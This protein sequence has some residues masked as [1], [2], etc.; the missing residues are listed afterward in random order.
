M[1]QRRGSIL[2]SSMGMIGL[3]MAAIMGAM[4]YVGNRNAGADNDKFRLLAEQAAKTGMEFVLGWAEASIDK[5]TRLPRSWDNMND[6]QVLDPVAQH[7]AAGVTTFERVRGVTTAGVGGILGPNS[8][9]EYVL[10]SVRDSNGNAAYV[11]S[12]KARVQ[13]F[14]VSEDMPRQFKVGVVG[15]VRKAGQNDPAV[16]GNEQGTIVA[17][18]VVLS[19]VGKEPV[20]RYAA[21]IDTDQVRNWVP[22]EV[23]DGPVHINRGYVDLQAP[24]QGSGY[25]NQNVAIGNGTFI[26]SQVS[27]KMRS[28]MM[29]YVSGSSYKAGNPGFTL[30]DKATGN[31]QSINVTGYPVFKDV[32]SV[33]EMGD[34]SGPLNDD[35][36]LNSPPWAVMINGQQYFDGEH[37]A[38]A[39][40]NSIFTAP[41]NQN[42]TRYGAAGIA[43]PVVRRQPV[44]LPRSVRNR[45]LS[46]MGAP[47]GANPNISFLLDERAS[48]A[49]PYVDA[50]GG[51]R[52]GVYVPTERFWMSGQTG[53]YQNATAP[54]NISGNNTN[55]AAGGIYIRGTVELMRF[56]LEGKYAIYLF[57]LGRGVGGGTGAGQPRS[58][59]CDYALVVNRSVDV[60]D[61]TAGFVWLRNLGPDGLD[62]AGPGQTGAALLPTGKGTKGGPKNNSKTNLVTN[63]LGGSIP[64]NSNTAGQ[65]MESFRQKGG[66]PGAIAVLGPGPGRRFPFNGVIFVDASFNDS[67]RWQPGTLPLT[68]HIL[69]LGDT[70][71]EKGRNRKAA[72]NGCDDELYSTCQFEDASKVNVND[73]PGGIGQMSVSTPASRL[74]IQCVGNVFIQNDLIAA[75]IRHFQPYVK[76]DPIKPAL[77]QTKDL[78]GIVSDRQILV[79]LMAGR[80]QNKRAEVDLEIHGSLAALGDPSQPYDAT[81]TWPAS[82]KVDHQAYSGSVGTEGLMMYYNVVENYNIFYDAPGGGAPTND[83]DITPDV[84]GVYAE[85]TDQKSQFGYPANPIYEAYGLTDVTP[86]NKNPNG[87]VRGNFRVFG[88]VTQ[89]R[90]GIVGRGDLSYDKDFVFDRRLL[91]LAPPIFPASTNMVVRSQSPFAPDPLDPNKRLYYRGGMAPAANTTDSLAFLFQ[92]GIN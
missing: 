86:V 77:P 37:P 59:C 32:V 34:G 56:G 73:L 92:V 19:Y 89:K 13:Q 84:A 82:V 62:T 11:V 66:V 91:T 75:S 55:F 25:R 46:A 3:F 29:L 71:T 21:L 61:P 64:V 48:T 20:T 50:A 65:N 10:G 58:F 42:V 4:A 85:Q 80:N 87:K 40:A 41:E 67:T 23:I 33:T 52:D 47:M 17:E 74:S 22:G 90:R 54:Q 30:T 31:A 5:E 70:G 60:T 76:E 38:M 72:I 45:L 16:D 88:S 78:L 7:A 43:G 14:R 26:D 79:G 6:G 24:S 27:T 8:V 2:I 81:T 35:P 9:S 28:A 63:L 36:D 15:R 18:R 49:H 44:E 1:M 83:P 53:A 39:V 68:G 57:R 69:A 12:F 51:L